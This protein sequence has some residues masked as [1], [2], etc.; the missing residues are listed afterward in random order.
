LRDIERAHPY[1]NFAFFGHCG[2]YGIAFQHLSNEKWDKNDRI[3]VFAND[4]HELCQGPNSSSVDVIPR[5]AEDFNQS[6]KDRNRTP[7]S[8]RLERYGPDKFLSSVL[9]TTIN[10]Q[11][12]YDALYDYFCRNV[13]AQLRRGLFARWRAVPKYKSIMHSQEGYV[14]FHTSGAKPED[15]KNFKPLFELTSKI[16]SRQLWDRLSNLN[17]MDLDT[18]HKS[19]I[20]LLRILDKLQYLRE[21]PLLPIRNPYDPISIFDLS[22]SHPRMMSSTL[23]NEMAATES[24]DPRTP[25]SPTRTTSDDILNRLPRTPKGLAAYMSA[26]VYPKSTQESIAINPGI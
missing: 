14:D 25:T 16:T 1:F 4:F 18:N 11:K 3:R 2:E 6:S 8:S 10:P 13:N 21:E 23:P 26:S 19:Y 7:V 20:S 12:H 24:R 5:P 22:P 17:K 15:E 9:F